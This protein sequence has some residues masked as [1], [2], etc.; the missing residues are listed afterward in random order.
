MLNTISFKTYPFSYPI[1]KNDSFI[2]SNKYEELKRNWPNFKFFQ[3]TSAGQISRNNIPL[4]KNNEN[5]KKINPLFRELFDELDSIS[6][7]KFLTTK[8]NFNNAKDNEG[9]IGDFNTSELV[10]YIAESTDGYENPWH[11]DTR[12]RIIHFLIYFGDET[13]K[14]GGKLG[15]A[16][17]KKLRS[18]LDY[19]QYPNKKDLHDTVYFRPNNNVGIF[20]LSQNNSFHKVSSLIGLRRF[21]YAGYTNKLGDAWKTKGWSAN[22]SFIQRLDQEKEENNKVN[23]YKLK[24]SVKSIK[25]KIVSHFW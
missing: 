13:I 10:L 1:L 16:N 4:K 15:I 14:N 6:F 20:I 19:K 23:F 2:D 18:F 12:G 21:I 5:Y 22:K 7:R 8:F 11:V 9:F 24:K 17:H 25:S 3:T